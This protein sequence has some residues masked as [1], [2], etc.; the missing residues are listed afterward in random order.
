MDRDKRLPS[1]DLPG[2]PG[3]RGTK[4]S[5][6]G[7]SSLLGPGFANRSAGNVGQSRVNQDFRDSFLGKPQAKT[8]D[9]AIKPDPIRFGR[10]NQAIGN[11]P[12]LAQV[13]AAA[14]AG[15]S[16]QRLPK[17]NAA[18]PQFFGGVK[19]VENFLGAS[20]PRTTGSVARGKALPPTT[21]APAPVQQPVVR[22]DNQLFPAEAPQLQRPAAEPG[23]LA[24]PVVQAAPPIPTKTA[25]EPTT[26]QAPAAPTE[27]FAEADGSIRIIRGNFNGTGNTGFGRGFDV[28]RATPDGRGG[29]SAIEELPRPGAQTQQ[30]QEQ[31]A[32]NPNSAAGRQAQTVLNTTNIAAANASASANGAGQ[33]ERIRTG[34]NESNQRIAEIEAQNKLLIQQSEG[35][36]SQSDPLDEFG[37]AAAFSDIEQSR[38]EGALDFNKFKKGVFDASGSS[39][40]S[41]DVL[42][43]EYLKYLDSL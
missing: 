21:A 32:A 29:F 12:A 33:D 15:P 4:Q 41:E 16:D 30:L 37:D 1:L 17:P 23:V 27:Q 35:V 34:L 25:P 39:D 38:P 9:Q 14:P 2:Y 8:S 36:G 13:S 28:S 18:P 11:N 3:R 10:T 24:A 26:A 42:Q 40:F 19:G 22:A 6:R 5:R 7:D 43:T 20:Q 31:A